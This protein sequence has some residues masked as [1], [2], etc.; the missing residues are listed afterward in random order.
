MGD[1][2]FPTNRRKTVHDDDT[3]ATS[4]DGYQPCMDCRSPTLRAILGQHG[5]RCIRCYEDWCRSGPCGSGET[6]RPL[7]HD[8]KMAILAK[9]RTTLHAMTATP[10]D[11]KQWARDLIERAE[12]GEH[13]G[14]VQ[15]EMACRAL[16][17]DRLPRFAG[18]WGDSDSD[19]IERRKRATQR[20][21]EEYRRDA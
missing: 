7:T 8:D 16:G 18:D 14:Y 3:S 20:A 9:L 13:V 11:P 2:R 10:R 15:H 5:A 17:V 19:D 1:E 12:R 6:K 21:V 4:D